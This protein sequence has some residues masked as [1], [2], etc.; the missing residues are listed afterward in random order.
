MALCIRVFMSIFVTQFFYWIYSFFSAISELL[1]ATSVIHSIHNSCRH[2][3]I[4]ITLFFRSSISLS[5][6][7]PSIYK[8]FRRAEKKNIFFLEYSIK[9]KFDFF[10]IRTQFVFYIS[11]K[12][13]AADIAGTLFSFHFT[14]WN[15]EVYLFEA[16]VFFFLFF[17]RFRPA[18]SASVFNEGCL[19]WPR[20]SH[21]TMAPTNKI[22]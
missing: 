10:P 18:S 20:V 14:E 3:N 17:F 13:N 22:S 1:N 19:L 2:T 16:S 8:L 4:F 5:L 6:S 9:L 11:N 7:L 15:G 12:K 21:H